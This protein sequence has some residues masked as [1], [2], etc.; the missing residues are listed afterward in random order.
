MKL[1]DAFSLCFLVLIVLLGVSC[2]AA[3]EIGFDK[4]EFLT[5]NGKPFSR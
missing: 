5:I 3:L 1:R 2:Q 4:N